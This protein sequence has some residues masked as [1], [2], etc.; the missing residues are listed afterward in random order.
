MAY[1]GIGP[2]QV[3]VCVSLCWCADLCVWADASVCVLLLV[4]VV[5]SH[6]LRPEGQRVTLYTNLCHFIHAFCCHVFQ[7]TNKVT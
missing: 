1:Y 2:P 5:G 6:L 4:C 7:M 3:C